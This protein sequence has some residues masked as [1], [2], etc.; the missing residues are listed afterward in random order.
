M[1]GKSAEAGQQQWWQ[2]DKTPHRSSRTGVNA[3]HPGLSEWEDVAWKGHAGIII[4][5]MSKK[6]PGELFPQQRTLT[7][8]L[9]IHGRAF[10]FLPRFQGMTLRITKSR[11]VLKGG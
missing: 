3:H 8:S 7:Q 6:Q 2:R 4:R 5:K 11:G 1:H 9:Y 10:E